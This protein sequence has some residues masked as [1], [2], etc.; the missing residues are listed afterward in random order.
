MELFQPEQ[1]KDDGKTVL[2]LDSIYGTEDDR[3]SLVTDEIFQGALLDLHDQVSDDPIRDHSGF[4][5]AKGVNMVPVAG[6]ITF[7]VDSETFSRGVVKDIDRLRCG[8]QRLGSG[9]SLRF[10]GQVQGL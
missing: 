10:G 4:A 5:N 6:K 7:E 3:T 9:C 8:F 1:A 2:F